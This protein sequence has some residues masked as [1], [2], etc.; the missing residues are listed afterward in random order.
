MN[1]TEHARDKSIGNN[2]LGVVFKENFHLYYL[3]NSLPV[4]YYMTVEHDLN[5]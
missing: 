2:F 1:A 4:S 5:Q 3:N